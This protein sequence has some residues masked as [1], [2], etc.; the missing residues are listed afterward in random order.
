M[1]KSV[2]VARSVLNRLFAELGFK[3]ANAW[4]TQRLQSKMETLKGVADKETLAKLDPEDAKLLRSLL[5]AQK[6]GQ[7]IVITED[8][9]DEAPAP[10]APAPK[11]PAAKPKAAPEPEEEEV[12]DEEEEVEDEEE[13]EPDTEEEETEDESPPPKKKPA[14]KKPVREEPEDDEEVEDTRD[15]EAAAEEE[16]EETGEPAAPT[17]P[18]KRGGPPKGTGKK[19]EKA[20]EPGQPGI[21]RSI[22]E[23]LQNA[24]EDKP[25]TKQAIL[26]K[27]TKRFPDRDPVKMAKTVAAQ[28]P[29]R[30]KK[31]YK[32]Q[33][34]DTDSGKVYWIT[35]I[36]KGSLTADRSTHPERNTRT[37]ENKVNQM[38]EEEEAQEEVA[39]DRKAR[40]KPAAQPA[41][42]GVKKK[43]VAAAVADDED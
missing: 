36:V 25:L 13:S 21:I 3:T 17:P 43:P 39:Q 33:T 20:G 32:V 42:Q 5:T 26:G 14:T 28:V 18:R 24:T 34:E 31:A 27:L 29:N 37:A 10:K 2:K 9:E 30:I 16:E 1:P 23:F 6:E 4:T 12:E 41:K 40:A 8:T 11:K 22:I 7:E 35:G 38:R 19:P 15:E